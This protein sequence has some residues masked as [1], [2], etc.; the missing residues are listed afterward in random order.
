MPNAL[1]EAMCLGLPVISTAVSGTS[2]LIENGVNGNVTEVGNKEQMVAAMRELLA[3][4]D[5]RQKYAER[6]VLVND[7]LEVNGIMEEWQKFIEEVR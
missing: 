3:S 6:A 7:K 4:A 5:M 2:D 1:I